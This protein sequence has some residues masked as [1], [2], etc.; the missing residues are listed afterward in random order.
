MASRRRGF[1]Q[2]DDIGDVTVVGF[3]SCQVLD[4]RNMLAAADEL[5]DIIDNQGRRKLLLSF[6][7][8][9]YISS[10]ALGTLITL[11]KRLK[12][13]GG[14]LVLCNLHPQLYEV[15]EA[16]KLNK[17]FSIQR[18]GPETEQDG[19]GSRLKPRDPPGAAPVILPFPPPESE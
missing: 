14:K 6:R 2:I 10:T 5:C 12:E 18:D 11:N 1:L 3:V 7:T 19:V 9:E 4:E 13:V 16:A 17:L 15:F 8:V